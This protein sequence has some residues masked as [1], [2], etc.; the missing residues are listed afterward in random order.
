[1]RWPIPTEEQR[2]AYYSETHLIADTSNHQQSP[3]YGLQ[4]RVHRT[5]PAKETMAP[6]PLPSPN[7]AWALGIGVGERF[8]MKQLR[9]VGYP[10]RPSSGTF[11]ASRCGSD[12]V[13]RE[14]RPPLII[15]H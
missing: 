14:D 6:V 2:R 9:D 10:Q 8:A 5:L 12:A 7:G 15:L 3:D 1:M 4:E 13:G 11:S